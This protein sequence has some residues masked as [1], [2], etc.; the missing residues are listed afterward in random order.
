MQL[1]LRTLLPLASSLVAALSVASLP[2]QSPWVVWSSQQP[3]GTHRILQVPEASG[4]GPPVVV[5][6]GA[7]F[8]DLEVTNRTRANALRND[9]SRRVVRDGSAFVELPAGGSLH[10]YRRAQ[11]TVYGLLWVDAS[12]EASP[13]VEH[14]ALPGGADPF[15]DRIGVA[16][17]GL[18]VA[19]P[20]LD[21]RVQIVR[22]DGLNYPSTGAPWRWAGLPSSIETTSLCP[23]QTSL[24][25]GTEDDRVWQIPY[26]DG[27]VAIE[28][29]P[30]AVPNV[31]LKSEWAPS[32]DG[33]CAA[34]LYGPRDLYRIFRI[35][36][37]GPAIALSPP[38]AKYEEPG[39][40]PE[41]DFGPRLLLD[42]DGSELLFVDATIRDEAYALEIATGAITHVTGD[43][44]FQPY[45]GVVILP[46][47]I[48]D[49]F[50]AGIG[51]PLMFDL[52][53]SN[54]RAA[55]VANWTRTNGNVVAPFAEGSLELRAIHA[56]ESAVV[57]ADA[58]PTGSPIGALVEFG[59]TG[60]RVLVDRT[61]GAPELGPGLNR[62]GDLRV[63]SLDGTAL[64]DT[65]SLFP[66]LFAPPG[67]DLSPTLLDEGVGGLRSRALLAAAGPLRAVVLHLEGGQ[68]I[69]VPVP[70]TVRGLGRTKSGA[71]LLDGAALELVSAHGTRV[72]D[73]TAAPRRILSGR[74]VELP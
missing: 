66:F 18:H 45:I 3:D 48:A 50:V 53:A 49:S 36:S 26:A 56:S 15:D 60:P 20:L 2:A 16:A 14:P 21:G 65:R 9:H 46:F 34:F 61:L 32:G 6:D 33:S 68:P 55:D 51:D 19:V 41:T 17:D 5:L 57:Y 64:L 72:L 25:C 63:E 42:D 54:A 43:H 8:L 59:A 30:P 39:Y 11:G 28:R 13:L 44:N 74:S 58:K 40:L 38:P 27:A 67:V 70:S 47:A 10:A 69:G 73:A 35:G 23:L 1:S 7:E 4:T 24:V 37:T 62:R 71:L 22:L 31:R 29:T 12:G 52:Y